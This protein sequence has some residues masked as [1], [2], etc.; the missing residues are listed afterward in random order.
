MT[1]LPADLILCATARLSRGLQ[2][3][4]QRQ[5]SRQKTY[6]Q[7]QKKTQKNT[8]TPW[9]TPWLTQWRTPQI[10]TMQQWLTLFTQQSLLTGELEVKN[11]PI[12]CLSTVAEKMLWQEAI[13]SSIQKHE[14]AALFDVTGLADVAMQA[15]KLL[16]DWQISDAVLNAYYQSIETRQFLRWRESFRALCSTHNALEAPRFFALEIA[17]ITTTTLPLPSNIKLAGY[18]RL[19][20]LEQALIDNLTTK[21]VTVTFLQHNQLA[22]SVVQTGCADIDAECRA[23]VAWAQ[24]SLV[25]NPQANLAIITPVLGAIKSKLADLLD[26]T[27]HP[28]TL[29][30]SLY[31]QPRI[32][33]FSLGAPLSDHP[34]IASALRL[35]QVSCSSQAL[36]QSD[37]SAILLD[38]FWSDA[39]ETDVRHLLD[40]QMRKNCARNLNLQGLHTLTQKT[41][42]HMLPQFFA[43]L[44]VLQSAQ[45]N[46]NRVHKP[47]HWV[48]QFSQLL[49][50]V[51]WANT[52]Q[53]S[54]Y[55]YQAQQTWL[56]ILQTFNQWD[57][58]TG[59]IS[60]QNA[61]KHIIQ[62]CAGC[63]FLPETVG[64]PRIQL[65]GMLE[66]SAIALD[67]LWV[68]GLND[69]QWPPP[70]KPNA[71]LPIK[72][73][74]EKGMPNADT[75]IQATFAYKVQQRLLTSASEIV[76]SWAQ[77]EENR[78]LLPSPSL[79]QMAFASEQLHINTLAE[80][81][82][83][84]SAMARM[85]FLDDS[86]APA[87][88]QN[89]KLRGGSA[90]FEAQAVCPAWA[91]YQYRLGARALQS[92]TDGLDNLARGNLVHS[93]LQQFWLV[94][95]NAVNLKAMTNAKLDAA[96]KLAINT[97]IKSVTAHKFIP[98][99]ILN[100]ER[101]RLIP[102]IFTWL[103]LEKQRD[104][105]LVL[106]CEAQ[107]VLLIEGL[108]ITLR[109]DRIDALNDGSLIIIDY[110]TGSHTPNNSSWADARITKPQLPL[111]AALVFKD[112]HIAAA[113]FAKVDAL[114][115]QFSGVA[116]SDVLPEIKPF[117]TLKSGSIFNEFADF[118]ALISHW[119]QSLTNIA[120]EIKNGVARVKFENETDLTYCEVKPLLRLPERALQ[121]EQHQQ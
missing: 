51:N 75:D 31:E 57:N 2:L 72:L 4:Y 65:L 107:H 40:A 34:M 90:L 23:A 89:E 80:K 49:A 64:Q 38:N 20:P 79:D 13:Q 95:K 9:R 68:L 50:D 15:N 11:L 82:S 26:D 54:S 92:P 47:S 53:L 69:Q 45:A 71:L 12:V 116:V 117:D 5:L 8:Q 102:L 58:L 88:T 59:A 66:T 14:L 37:I 42:G 36:P 86:N 63:Q 93:V 17:N 83:A 6:K 1:S 87:I 10:L 25:K 111:Y 108:E 7:T 120:Y 22:S 112:D 16:V 24:Q 46:W 44:N 67:G 29:H 85:E 98:K 21:N 99:Q 43:H 52:R 55:E 105:F 74:R 109:I 119:Q 118:D 70:A 73:Q 60:A 110:K 18:D 39:S 100:I 32:T 101:Q 96:I 77:K 113:C 62:L 35:L 114:D 48:A 76:F 91:F 106:A 97:A 3:D 41:V 104:D 19:T 115:P 94:C 121:F 56:E 81:L 27:F 30:P 61:V 78:E 103:Q 84:L 33:D 28:E